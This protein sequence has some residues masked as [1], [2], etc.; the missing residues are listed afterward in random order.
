[1]KNTEKYTVIVYLCYSHD[2]IS[3]EKSE[4]AG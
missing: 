2:L 3:L 4:C 1:M